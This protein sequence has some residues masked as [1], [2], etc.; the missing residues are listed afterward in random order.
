MGGSAIWLR[1]AYELVQHFPQAPLPAFAP[2][3]SRPSESFSAG[4][5]KRERIIGGHFSAGGEKRTRCTER[6]PQ[7]SGCR[8]RVSQKSH[9]GLRRNQSGGECNPS[10]TEEE[11]AKEQYCFAPLLT[12]FQQ[13]VCLYGHV[14]TLQ[15]TKRVFLY[16]RPIARNRT[17]GDFQHNLTVRPYRF[18]SS[19][20]PKRERVDASM[21]PFCTLKRNHPGV[22][23]S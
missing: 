15:R 6:K 20:P 3:W 19:G 22:G 1:P 10:L 2:I 18:S 14:L 11:A 4:E 16:F 7:R 8:R 21:L 13:G 17:E 9:Y 12:V 23:N 5:D